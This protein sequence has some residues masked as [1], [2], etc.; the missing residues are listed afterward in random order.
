[1]ISNI[2][3]DRETFEANVGP[4][5]VDEGNGRY[6]LNIDVNHPGWSGI[7]LITGRGPFPQEVVAPQIGARG[8]AW[9]QEFLAGAA[10]G[11]WRVEMVWFES[12]NREQGDVAATPASV[13]VEAPLP[14]GDK[15]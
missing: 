11:N 15:E 10:D 2:V 13:P 1:M 6:R 7:I 12:V 5:I 9:Q 4:A 3:P 8:P 14:E